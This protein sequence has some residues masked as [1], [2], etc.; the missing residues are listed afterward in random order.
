M[1]DEHCRGLGGP[2]HDHI[3]TTFGINRNSILNKLQ[4]FHVVRGL[5][6]DVMHNILEGLFAS[7][8]FLTYNIMSLAYIT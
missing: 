3:S 5:V 2:L 8:N 6:P 7:R 1:Y 4:Y